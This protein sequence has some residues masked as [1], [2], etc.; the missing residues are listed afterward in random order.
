MPNLVPEQKK[1]HCPSGVMV[2]LHPNHTFRLQI[3]KPFPKSNLKDV[4]I[5]QVK[6]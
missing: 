4:S 1:I 3:V 6:T 2:N 5:G